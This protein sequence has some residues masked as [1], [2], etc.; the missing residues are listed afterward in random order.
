EAIAGD[1]EAED[2]RPDR[3]HGEGERGAGGARAALRPGLDEESERAREDSGDEEGAPD[4]PSVRRRELAA[5]EGRGEEAGEGGEHLDE[6]EGDRVVAGREALH[7][8][9]LERVDGG[10]AEY[11]QVPRRRAG[12]D[13][14]EH[15]EAGDGERNS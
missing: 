12:L 1:R 5:G 14:R 7:E 10:G 15:G 8:D 3:L 11:E 2:S 6:G 4:R 9:D 13:P